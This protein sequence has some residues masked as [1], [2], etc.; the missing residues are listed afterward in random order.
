MN[1][2][3]PTRHICG[4]P[5]SVPANPMLDRYPQ[6]ERTCKNC[7]AV[8]ITVHPPEG[9]G[10]RLWR[11]DGSWLQVTEEPACEQQLDKAALLQP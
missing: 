1:I 8:K 10:Y 6:T 2:R 7:G 5:V 3:P 4:D 9:G 11:R